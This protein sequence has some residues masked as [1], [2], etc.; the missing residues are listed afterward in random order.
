[1]KKV[2]YFVMSFAP[3]LA[4]AQDAQ[5]T[6]GNLETLVRGL[7]RVINV[8]IP[9]LFAVAILFFFWGLIQFLRSAGDPEAQ[10]AGKA[11]MIYGII[12]IFVMVSIYGLVAWLQSTLGV[13]NT[14][15]T[16][17]PEIPLR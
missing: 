16:T 2:I 13:T 9:V 6:T 8:I 3:V 17:L 5:T 4:L 15:T 10:K 11:H 14:S 1:M 12:A 7:G